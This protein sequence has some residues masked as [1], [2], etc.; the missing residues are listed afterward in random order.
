MGAFDP[1]PHASTHAPGGSDPITISG[2]ATIDT[3]TP[4]RGSSTPA[5]G[6]NGK[7]SDSGHV[8]PTG[9]WQP[10]DYGYHGFSFLPDMANAVGT[11]LTAGTLY[12]IKV[13]VDHVFT[14]TNLDA[15]VTTAA[16]GLTT[17]QS[18]GMLYTGAKALIGQTA[19]LSAVWTSTGLKGSSMSLAATTTGSLTNLPA[20]DYYIGFYATGTTPPVFRAGSLIAITNG[21]LTAANAKYATAD[22]GLTTAPPSTAGTFTA[23]SQ[24]IWA[25]VY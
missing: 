6:T 3:I 1:A 12:L 8:H 16:S 7:A 23:S 9:L 19:D 13:K 4:Q 17:G 25:G 15:Y 11:I 18:Y 2:G 5:A 21:R 20:G 22:T 14:P 10:G 24:A